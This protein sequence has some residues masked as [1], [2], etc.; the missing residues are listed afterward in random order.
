MGLLGSFARLMVF[1]GFVAMLRRVGVML[2]S[3]LV[4]KWPFAPL[5]ARMPMAIDVGAQNALVV[6]LRL[7][8]EE[9]SSFTRE[10]SCT[11]IAIV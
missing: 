7:N 2:R 4:V 10:Y 5:G 3:L 6:E 8:S 9:R 1:G 11:I